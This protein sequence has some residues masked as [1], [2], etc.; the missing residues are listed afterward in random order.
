MM[1]SFLIIIALLM[2]VVAVLIIRIRRE[3]KVIDRLLADR[4]RMMKEV[5]QLVK[6]KN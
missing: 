6:R 3:C 2:A 4:K 1:S 5:D